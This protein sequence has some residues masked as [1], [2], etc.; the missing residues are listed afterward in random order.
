MR[1]RTRVACL[2]TIQSTAGISRGVQQEV[3][4]RDAARD[5]VCGEI[6]HRRFFVILNERHDV[7]ISRSMG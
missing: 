3:V 2:R 1:L 5:L 4:A 6:A 7:I